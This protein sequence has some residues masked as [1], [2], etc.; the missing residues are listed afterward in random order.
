MQAA[1]EY[2]FHRV[3][4]PEKSMA[5]ERIK[6]SLMRPMKSTRGGD[7]GHPSK[8]AGGGSCTG[9]AGKTDGTAGP[10]LTPTFS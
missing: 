5:A 8:S 9:T 7:H 2:I 3:L 1:Q 4:R 10:G 6:N